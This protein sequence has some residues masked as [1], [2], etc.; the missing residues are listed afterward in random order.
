VFGGVRLCGK[1]KKKRKVK[2]IKEEQ[3]WLVAIGR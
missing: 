3:V 1:E 2:E